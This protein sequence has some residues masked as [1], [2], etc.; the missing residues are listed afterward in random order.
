MCFM[1]TDRD[2]TNS[3]SIKRERDVHN[4]SQRLGIDKDAVKKV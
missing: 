2:W 1:S 4:K 3:L